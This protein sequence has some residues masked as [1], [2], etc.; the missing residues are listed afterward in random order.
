MPAKV[1]QLGDADQLNA[2]LAKFDHLVVLMMENRS[3]DLPP[4]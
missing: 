3:F 2:N 4:L 1:L